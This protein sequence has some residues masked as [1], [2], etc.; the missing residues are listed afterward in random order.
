MVDS[1][2]QI[3]EST[4]RRFPAARWG[5]IGAVAAACALFIFQSGL[6]IWNKGPTF[7]EVAHIAA[8]QDYISRGE[9]VLNQE[10]PP[11]VKQLSGVAL[12][13]LDL[14]DRPPA[15]LPPGIVN[16]DAHWRGEEWT[17]GG[18]LLF[19]LN[20]DRTEEILRVARLPP[21]L[22]SIPFLIVLFLWTRAMVGSVAA[23][24]AL[25]L[26][27]F[28]PLLL[29][30]A[31]LV[32][33]DFALTL[34]VAAALAQ[35]WRLWR[36]FTWPRALALGLICGFALC[37]KYSAVLLGPI[38]AVVTLAEIARLRDGSA[39]TPRILTRAGE[40]PR[41]GVLLVEWLIVGA[42]VTAVALI[43]V[44]F[45]TW[46]WDPGWWFH[47]YS[48]LLDG[49]RPGFPFYCAER[50]S[51]TGFWYYFPLA[52]LVKTPLGA[53]GLIGVG[54]V[55]VAR[56]ESPRRG[57]VVIYLLV[58]ILLYHLIAMNVP[59][60][61]G[62]RH[63]LPTVAL[64]LIVA[65]AGGQWLWSLGLGGRLTLGA[66]LLAQ[67]VASVGA[68]PDYLSFFN[69]LAGGPRHGW[70]WLDD[71]NID[72]GQ[73]LPALTR[74]R[75]EMKRDH[76]DAPLA[77]LYFGSYSP[78]WGEELIPDADSGFVMVLPH[79]EYLA[80][81]T[82]HLIR[83]R[84]TV[85][86]DYGLPY[87]WD[88]EALFSGWIRNSYIVL[89]LTEATDGSGDIVIDGAEER[90]IPRSQWLADARHA[91]GVIE[92][93]IATAPRPNLM[94]LL[95]L[96]LQSARFFER[97]GE[98]EDAEKNFEAVDQIVRHIL[99]QR[100]LPLEQIPADVRATMIRHWTERG[101]PNRARRYQD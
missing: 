9:Y 100:G 52:L 33:T 59:I 61:L 15:P 97:W 67:V 62:V 22:L 53:L 92:R 11:L 14:K 78:P 95:Y 36:R 20:G 83:T 93:K 16:P 50:Y 80:I 34:F 54:L 49:L 25:A 42:A 84:R 85:E 69:A 45:S 75:A 87:P 99:V 88:D 17:S 46:R 6:A 63:V 39:S 29:A 31:P 77:V 30:H 5:A 51:V 23:L 56:M 21:L 12:S 18:A 55:S 86:Q 76:P 47:G 32:H 82:Q 48:T 64:L 66:L 7:D 98:T 101:A 94:D 73:D 26:A 58:P 71:S 60:Q 91:I 96:R 8:A 43:P 37:A 35:T 19:D 28:S 44:L 57:D 24:V 27:T 65:G 3:N 40:P 13:F 70:H 10:H 72:W 74:W 4:H 90:R 2:P 38:I 81:S 41:Q 1:P 68:A 89:H 79:W